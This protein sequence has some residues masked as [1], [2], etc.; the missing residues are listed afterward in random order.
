MG[1]DTCIDL[2]YNAD[3]TQPSEL[4]DQPLG[5]LRHP[6]FEIFLREYLRK[7]S[8][9]GAGSK[10]ARPLNAIIYSRYR[11]NQPYI[12]RSSRTSSLPSSPRLSRRSSRRS[13]LPSSSR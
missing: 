12:Y 1:L 8:H 5:L 9:F 13:I 3:L 7:T 4:R 10:L 6:P 11:L 2:F